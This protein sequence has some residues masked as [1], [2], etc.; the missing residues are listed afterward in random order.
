MMLTKKN[1]CL[2]WCSLI[3]VKSQRIGWKGNKASYWTNKVRFNVKYPFCDLALRPG[4]KISVEKKKY[5][6]QSLQL[7]IWFFRQNY[8]KLQ[9]GLSKIGGFHKNIC[10]QISIENNQFEVKL[11]SA[12]FKSKLKI[13]GLGRNSKFVDNDHHNEH[14]HNNNEQQNFR[15]RNTVFFTWDIFQ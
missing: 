5:I 14:N 13:T 15:Q 12:I 1:L 4:W 8:K 11:I 3:R 2:I 7:F 6:R 10:P 9:V